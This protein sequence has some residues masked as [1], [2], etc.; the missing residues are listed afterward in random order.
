VE[1][2]QS[3]SQRKRSLVA[4]ARAAIDGPREELLK[5]PT[6]LSKE[7]PERRMQALF[8]SPLF[9]HVSISIG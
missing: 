8:K 2:T 1:L 4:S 6:G 9:L 3:N 7:F 5:E